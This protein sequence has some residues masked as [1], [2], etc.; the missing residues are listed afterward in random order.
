MAAQVCGGERQLA[1]IRDRFWSTPGGQTVRLTAESKT[2]FF[3]AERDAQIT[4][5]RDASG[6]VTGLVLHQTGRDTPAPKVR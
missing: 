1:R 2:E 6:A 5:K 3:V 4:F